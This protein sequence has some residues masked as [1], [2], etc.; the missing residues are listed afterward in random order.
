M[1]TKI[2]ISMISL[3][4]R[5]EVLEKH[6]SKLKELALR[7]ARKQFPKYDINYSGEYTL[8]GFLKK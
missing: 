2:V 3:L 5:T 7:R 6:P 4:K 8:A 1:E